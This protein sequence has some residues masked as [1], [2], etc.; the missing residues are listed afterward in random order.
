MLFSPILYSDTTRDAHSCTFK[1]FQ[2][3]ISIFNEECKMN[4]C[5]PKYFWQTFLWRWGAESKYSFSVGSLNDHKT[6]AFC[7]DGKIKMLQIKFC[8]FLKMFCSDSDVGV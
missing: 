2:G 8:R 3:V 7:I 4:P 6:I 1:C 5:S